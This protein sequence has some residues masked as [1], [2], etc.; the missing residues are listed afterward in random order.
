MEQGLRPPPLHESFLQSDCNYSLRLLL[1][2]ALWL[3][4]VLARQGKTSWAAALKIG[5][6]VAILYFL[7]QVNDW[8][9]VRA[10]YDTHFTYASF[11]LRSLVFMLLAALGTGLTVSLVLP[12]GEPLYREARPER[13]RLTKAFS[14]RGM[15]SKEFFVPA[16]L[17]F[18]L[19]QPTSASLL[20]FTWLAANSESGRRRI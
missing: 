10:G 19:P 13:L 5:V 14:L 17:G 9:A 8:G 12:G 16:W 6:V 15:R 20:R 1:G 11:V 7:M 4:I 2:G 18:L 3:G